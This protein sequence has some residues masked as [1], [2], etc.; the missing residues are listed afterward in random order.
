METAERIAAEEKL[1]KEKV[2]R[3][4]ERMATEETWKTALKPTLL[5]LGS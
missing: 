3:T 4:A 1:T 5:I 2:E